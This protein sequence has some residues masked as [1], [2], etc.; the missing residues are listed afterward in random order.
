MTPI[1]C[2]AQDGV[3]LVSSDRVTANTRSGVLRFTSVTTNDAGKYLCIASNVVG[4]MTAERIVDVHSTPSICFC[5]SLF[6]IIIIII[7]IVIVHVLL[8]Y[9]L[10]Y[11]LIL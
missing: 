11:L 6:I 10:I 4:R 8:T 1:Q 3:P 5:R 2:G 9:V 7:I